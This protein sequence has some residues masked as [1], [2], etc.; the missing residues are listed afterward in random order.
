MSRDDLGFVWHPQ[1]F[2][3][4]RAMLHYGPVGMTA[5]DHPYQWFRYVV[6]EKRQSN[7]SASNPQPST[8]LPPTPIVSAGA[9]VLIWPACRLKSCESSIKVLLLSRSLSAI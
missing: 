6:H 3:L 7:Y 5:H 9:T 8:Y 2:K 4:L 1:L